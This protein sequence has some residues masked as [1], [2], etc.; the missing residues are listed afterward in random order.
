MSTRGVLGYR[1]D[2]I[3]FLHYNSHDSYPAGLGRRVLEMV[4]NEEINPITPSIED[5]ATEFI[6]DSVMCQ[7]AYVINLD[8]QTMEYYVGVNADKNAPGRY[9]SRGSWT[10][11]IENKEYFGVKLVKIIP[12]DTIRSTPEADRLQL[13]NE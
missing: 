6:G 2:G 7:Y 5:D 12:L 11:P 13:F 9:V 3:D 1:K 8:D 4:Q 10:D